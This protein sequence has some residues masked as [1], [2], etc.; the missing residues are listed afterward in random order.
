VTVS[1]QKKP[2]VKYVQLK[3]AS[4][5]ELK[6]SWNL[7]AVLGDVNLTD[8]RLNN[9]IVYLAAILAREL[10]VKLNTRQTE[11]SLVMEFEFK[12]SEFDI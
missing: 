5:Q 9:A 1:V 11:K 3:A 6:Q 4:E 7:D 2:G 8:I 12:N 10:K